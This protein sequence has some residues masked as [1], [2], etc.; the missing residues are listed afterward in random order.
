MKRLAICTGG[1]VFGFVFCSQASGQGGTITTVAGNGAVGSFFGDGGP[2]TSAAFVDPWG[3][4]VD[5]SGNLFISDYWNDRIRK[6]SANGIITTVAGTGVKLSTFNPDTGFG[7]FSGDGGPASSASLSLPAGIAL[8]ALG[9]LFIADSMSQR[10][11]KISASG[12]ITTVAGSAASFGIVSPPGFSGDGGPATSAQLNEPEGV[13]VDAAGNLF[14]ADTGNH[15]IRKVSAGGIITTVAGYSQ[16]FSGD[17]GPALAAQLSGPASVAVDASGNLFIADLGNLRIRKVS[18]AGIITTVAGNGTWGSSGDGRPA[19]SAELSLG[20]ACGIAADS[21]G[22]LFLSDYGNS[23]IRKVS[24]AGIITTVAG[25]GLPGFSGDGGPAASASLQTP[26]GI[27]LD[28][29][30]NLFVADSVRI[31]KVV[32]VSAVGGSSLNVSPANLSFS[33]VA[34]TSASQQIN[35]AGVAGVAWTA[36]AS[37]SWI[38]LTP[39]AGTGPAT[40]AVAVNTTALQPGPYTATITISN[41]QVFPRQE[42]ITVSLT[43]TPATL[44]VTPAALNL[45]IPLEPGAQSQ[46]EIAGTAAGAAWQAKATTS[47]GGAWLTV[48]PAAGQIPA[49]LT[50][51]VNA[52]SLTAGTYQGSIAIQAAGTTPSS[53]TIGV[54]LT[55]TAAP[56][57]GQNQVIVTVAGSGNQGPLVCG[58]LDGPCGP[59]TKLNIGHPYALGFDAAGNLYIGQDS[60]L[61]PFPSALY[62]LA[63]NGV[64]T[65]VA[66]GPSSFFTVSGIQVLPNG[67][68]YL[69]DFVGERVLLL[70]PGTTPGGVTI[71]RIAGGVS[72]SGLFLP[73]FG[74]DGGPALNARFDYPWG[75]AF[76]SAGNLYISDSRNNRIRRVDSNGIINTIAG[77]GDYGPSGDNGPASLAKLNEPSGITIAPSGDLYIVDSGTRVRKV[78][79]AGPSGVITTVA[80][81]LKGASSVVVGQNG[82]VYIAEANRILKV[83]ASGG[84]TTVVGNGTAGYSGD[85]GPPA[86]ALVNLPGALA[87]DAIG[88]LYIADSGNNRVRMIVRALAGIQNAA[89]YAT[90]AVSPGEI[91]IL[92][93]AGMGPAALAT[94]QVDSTT[95]LLQTTVAGTTVLFNGIPAPVVYT[96]ANQVSVVVPYE[97][98]G[99]ATAQVLVNYQG[100]NVA[101]GSVPVVPSAPGIFT[102]NAGTGQAA[103]LNQDGSLNSAS[104]PAAAGS[105]IVLYLTGEGQTALPGVDGQIAAAAPYPAPVLPVTVTIGGQPATYVYAG[106]APGEVAGVMQINASIPAGVTGNAVPVSVQIGTVSAQKG[107]TV[108]VQ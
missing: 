84:I 1:L 49:W 83:S 8:D 5:A 50:L 61:S 53:S 106:A 82:N 32:P 103:A 64:I 66:G 62:K 19:T 75:V 39:I 18:T 108:A 21:F 91:V 71:Q 35:L 12:T 37:S 13:A 70:N 65:T 17:G 42:A 38:S 31:R 98:A 4:A 11:R 33:L 93:G 88:N 9:N 86:A 52:A 48:S 107:L 76:D 55:V 46:L 25:N 58:P 34:G 92:Y 95:G 94:L 85:G 26:E 6:V 24:A 102:M 28:A 16:G 96:S 41:P 45:Q 15:R 36:S 40:V 56:Q 81:D 59:A 90:G 77:T 79:P 105:T 47:T 80:G 54:T 27:T 73:N 104:N 29:A 97:V 23:L 87:L 20:F 89:S 68:L 10:I 44:S 78:S 43:V 67:S 14:I 60:E 63:P 57:S 101:A 30:G 22:N 74:G 51:L 3:V 69:A 99:A 100:N 2:A 72:A 7:G